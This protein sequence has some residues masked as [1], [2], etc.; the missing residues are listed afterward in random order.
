VVNHGKQYIQAH[1]SIHKLLEQHLQRCATFAGKKSN[2]DNKTLKWKHI[3][4]H[5]SGIVILKLN[6]KSDNFHSRKQLKHDVSSTYQTKTQCTR[7]NGKVSKL[8][9][10]TCAPCHGPVMNFTGRRLFVLR[11]FSFSTLLYFDF[12][13]TVKTAGPKGPPLKTASYGKTYVQAF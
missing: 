8:F 4:F 1:T 7:I 11:I 12:V 3:I 2:I 6:L 10:T 5:A 9:L 13:S